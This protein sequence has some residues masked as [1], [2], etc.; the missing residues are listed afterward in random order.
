M[1]PFDN[2]NDD[3]LEKLRMENEFK[4]MKLMLEH[5]AHFSEFPGKTPL[6]PAIE[7]EFLKN[8]EEFE[9][10]F[11][12]AD[13][14]LLYDFIERPDYTKVEDIPDDKIGAELDRIM[15]ILNSNG[16]QL[17]TICDVEEREIYRFITEELFAHEM[18]NIRIKGMMS[19]FIYEEFHP[20]HDYDIRNHC[21]DAISDYFRKNH[22]DHALFF[23]REASESQ[24]YNNFRDAFESFTL[25]SFEITDVYINNINASVSFKIDFTGTIEGSAV[26]QRFVGPGSAQMLLEHDF[27]VIMMME[28]PS[29]L[30]EG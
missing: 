7:N 28:L 19:C 4:K 8:I 21:E 1:L 20:N 3:E 18:D 29:V 25:H 22:E 13:T 12:H 26:Q 14:I 5:G 24:W 15:A 23:T 6:D 10:N 17:D 9:K 2:T 27:W 16:I 11:H 30:K